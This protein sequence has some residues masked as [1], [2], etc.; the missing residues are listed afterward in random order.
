[1]SPTPRFDILAR[2][3]HPMPVVPLVGLSVDLAVEQVLV[4]QADAEGPQSGDLIAV[5]HA[6]APEDEAYRRVDALHAM[7][8]QRELPAS[9]VL[10]SDPPVPDKDVWFCVQRLP[11]PKAVPS[12]KGTR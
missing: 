4:L 3:V 9:A 2:V 6:N 5:A 10:W 11:A 1:M 7:R 12:S 8:V